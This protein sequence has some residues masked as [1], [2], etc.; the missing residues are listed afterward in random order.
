[1][2]MVEEFAPICGAGCPLKG[3]RK[4]GAEES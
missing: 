1:M 4:L 3:N 2:V